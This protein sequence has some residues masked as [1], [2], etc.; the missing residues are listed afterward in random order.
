[1]QDSHVE[2]YE[3]HNRPCL[4]KITHPREIRL[5]GIIQ[6]DNNSQFYFIP[7]NT[8]YDDMN[9]YTFPPSIEQTLEKYSYLFPYS[10]HKQQKMDKKDKEEINKMLDGLLLKGFF[11][12]W[13]LNCRYPLIKL[14]ED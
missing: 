11:K 4:T 3:Q 8:H 9:L 13:L 6:I 7:R 5:S 1:M 12:E 2:Y 14:E 10:I